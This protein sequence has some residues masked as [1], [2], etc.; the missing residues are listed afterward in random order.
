[1]NDIF[2]HNTFAFGK[3][4]GQVDHSFRQRVHKSGERL[5]YSPPSSEVAELGLMDR[6]VQTTQATATSKE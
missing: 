2:D 4:K 1:M 3:I 5:D 6:S